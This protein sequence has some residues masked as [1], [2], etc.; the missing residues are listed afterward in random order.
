VFLQRQ[1]KI[2]GVLVPVPPRGQLE[3]RRLLRG[4]VEVDAQVH[5]L[6]PLFGHLRPFLGSLF[7]DTAEGGTSEAG[8][9]SRLLHAGGNLGWRRETRE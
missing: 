9:M 5:T 2:G 7:A 1:R 8:P 6:R 3:D 4:A